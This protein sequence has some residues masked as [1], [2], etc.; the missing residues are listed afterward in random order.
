MTNGG[1][2]SKW[3]YG[4]WG[5]PALAVVIVMVVAG[6]LMFNRTTQGFISGGMAIVLLVWF[7]A[8]GAQTERRERSA[9]NKMQKYLD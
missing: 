8:L 1:K 9:R 6:V 7:A 2:V 4:N 3:R 5:W